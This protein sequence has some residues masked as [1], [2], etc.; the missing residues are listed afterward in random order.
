MDSFDRKNF[1]GSQKSSIEMLTGGIKALNIEKKIVWKSRKFNNIR[2]NGNDFRLSETQSK[3][4]R[5]FIFGGKGFLE[6]SDFQ[7][8]PWGQK[9][10]K[11]VSEIFEW[12][13]RDKSTYYRFF[14]NLRTFEVPTHRT[15]VIVFQ[16]NAPLH[17]LSFRQG[18]CWKGSRLYK[19][20][21]TVFDS[22]DESKYKS[23]FSHCSDYQKSYVTIK[24][25]CF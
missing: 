6:R 15:E 21:E 25:K 18:N 5:K 24:V 14:W 11:V 2:A 4:R 12:E 20:I 23:L 1:S 19:L 7:M 22:R 16:W 10:K 9:S 17:V 3:S 8:R 13:G